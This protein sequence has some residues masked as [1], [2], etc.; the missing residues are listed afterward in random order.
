LERE[1]IKMGDRGNI[2][3]RFGDND[4][5]WFYTHWRGYML[6]Q[7]V[8]N[9][10]DR[11]ER[12]DDPSYLARIIFCELCPIE[13]HE[14][15]TGFG[16]SPFKGDDN[17]PDVVVLTDTQRVEYKNIIYPYETFI[18]DWINIDS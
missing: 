10:L 1:E 5:V 2:Q 7:I 17:Y 3:V 15:E 13:Q 6:P 16:I 9:A 12:W 11:H 18:E 8:A 14:D 4:S